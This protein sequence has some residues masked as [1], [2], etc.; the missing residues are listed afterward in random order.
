MDNDNN[1][2]RERIEENEGDSCE[3]SERATETE[4]RKILLSSLNSYFFSE[5]LLFSYLFLAIPTFLLFFPNFR[6]TVC[7]KYTS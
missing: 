3:R 7:P 2:D 6:W 1:S 4:N 5:F